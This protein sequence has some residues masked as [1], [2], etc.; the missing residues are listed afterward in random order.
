M[1]HFGAEL[2]AQRYARSRP[3]FHPRVT[4]LIR[5]R[6]SLTAPANRALDVGCGTGQSS[7]AL[8]PI[9]RRIVGVDVSAG[10][11]AHASRRP[12]ISYLQASAEHLP[13]GDG[14]FDLLTAGLALHWFDRD[15]FLREA[16]RV[17]R[18][19]G[20]LVI[21]NDAFRGDMRQNPAFAAWS[22]D[23]HLKRF[24]TP[25]RDNRP[26]SAGEALNFGFQ[27]TGREDFAHD[28]RFGPAELADY[29]LTQTNTIAQVERGNT[30]VDGVRRWLLDEVSRFFPT[31]SADFAF[32]GWV[33]YLHRLP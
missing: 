13:F 32:A 16:Q 25:P 9:A 15:R 6:L 2:V 30:S 10:M 22:R 18:P 23:V 5:A 20:W 26:L 27:D 8:L 7:V 31:E 12:G 1:N 4:Q 29:L 17:L 24:P 14:E 11:L 28:E 19:G 21:Y 33:R 3:Y